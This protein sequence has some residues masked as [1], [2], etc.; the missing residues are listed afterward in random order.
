MSYEDIESQVFKGDFKGH[1]LKRIFEEV[2]NHKALFFGFTLTILLTAFIDSF[3]TYLSKFLIDEGV[4]G[5]SKDALYRFALYQFLCF[6]VNG[7]SVFTF[8]YCADR[9]GQQMQYDLRKKLFGHL[10]GLSFS[11]F[12]KTSSGWLLSRLTSD[13]RRVSEL[14][15]WMLLDSLWGIS[16]ILISLVFMAMISWKLTLV[17]LVVIP[18][19]IFTAI[20]FRGRIIGEYRKVRSINSRLT[21]SYSEGIHGV[22]VAK[23]VAQEERNLRHFGKL[24]KDMYRASFRAAWL[25]SLFLPIV[26]LITSFGV[27]AIILYGGW[28]SQWGGLTIGGLRAFIGYV[29]FMMWPVQQMA[30]VFSEM[31]QAIASAERLFALLDL[32]ADIEDSPDAEDAPRFKG[33]VEFRRVDFHYKPESP[34]FQGFNLRVEAGETIAVVGPTGGGKTTLVNLI[35]RYYEPVGGEVLLDGRDYREFTQRGIQRRIGVVLQTPHLFSGTVR[36]NILYGRLE[37]SEEEMMEAS[38]LACAHAMVAQLPRG[39]DE[40][41]GEE[42]TFLSLGQRQLVS[43]ARTILADPDIIIMDEATSSVDT[44]TE[45]AIQEGMEH[46][47]EGRTAFIVAHRLSTIRKADRILL[48]EE[49]RIKEEGNHRQLLKQKGHYYSLYTSQFRKDNTPALLR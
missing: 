37:A 48:I 47:L 20:K 12:D 38:R 29:T 35:S 21:S 15:S 33:D 7:A 42:G 16:N 4:V 34:I 49:G 18:A 13:V 31:Q 43:L 45:E 28:E 27:G 17:M 1:T 39:Y 2:W 32:Q 6:V 11:F 19:L 40:F 3:S 10:Q 26:S 23:A 25:S 9:L 41:V 5:R 8:I 22:R 44:R 46:L 24:S 14:I 30:R 36:E